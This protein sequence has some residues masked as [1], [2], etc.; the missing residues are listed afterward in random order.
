MPSNDSSM[1]V[2]LGDLMRES[3]SNVETEEAPLGDPVLGNWILQGDVVIIRGHDAD[4]T[5][6]VATCLGLMIAGGWKYNGGIGTEKCRT[7]YLDGHHSRQQVRNRLTRLVPDR[8]PKKGSV[9][10]SLLFLS[11]TAALEFLSCWLDEPQGQQVVKRVLETA[12]SDPFWKVE[13]RPLVLV[14]DNLGA[15]LNDAGAHAASVRRFLS[16]LMQLRGCGA[17]FLLVDSVSSRP[18]MA[19]MGLIEEIS[20]LVIGVTKLK[21]SKI[22]APDSEIKLKLELR[23]HRRDERPALVHFAYA[24]EI[25]EK[26]EGQRRFAFEPYQNETKKTLSDDQVREAHR[27]H[28]DEG[29]TFLQLRTL[30]GVSIK[31]LSAAFKALHL[32][33]MPRGRKPAATTASNHGR[34][35]VTKGSPSKPKPNR[36]QAK[37]SGEESEKW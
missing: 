22:A 32:K 31:T 21:A 9:Q 17:T 5:S 19:G 27:L 35:K 3:A 7:L 29:K 14:I 6:Y 15:W 8:G 33:V 2:S 16:W 13:A 26:A 18:P 37:S 12:K 36:A 24:L 11:H 10:K 30:Y 20:H 28:C 4:A 25:P 23:Q 34:P 1:A